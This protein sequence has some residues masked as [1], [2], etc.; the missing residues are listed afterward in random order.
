MD[1]PSYQV[2]LYSDTEN[3][4]GLQIQLPLPV[5]SNSCEILSERATA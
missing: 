1:T 3:S 5:C 2:F 4:L